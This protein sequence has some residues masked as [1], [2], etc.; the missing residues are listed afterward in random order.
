MRLV[1]SAARI[2]VGVGL[3]ATLSLACK[4]VGAT[5][6]D[7]AR[8]DC[9]SGVRLTAKDAPLSE[10]LQRLSV[11]LGFQMQLETRLDSLVT[12]DMA[13]PA[14]ELIARLTV[15]ESAMT[16]YAPDPRCPGRS[17]V[18]RLWILP[19]GDPRAAP[20]TKSA[21]VPVTQ[22]ATREQ[23]RAAEERSRQLKADYEA[24]V[25]THGKPPPGEE[26]EAARP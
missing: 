7:I 21:P 12:L 18:V 17:R 20:P 22:T 11:V 25:R 3:A 14:T 1:R 13:A 15:Q 6:I 8:G 24:Y 4:A 2:A 16:S 9:N 26:E 5:R 19:R 10:V 23:L